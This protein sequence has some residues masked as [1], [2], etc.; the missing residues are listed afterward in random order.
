MNGNSEDMKEWTTL[1]FYVNGRRIEE[2]KADPKT[3]LA[4]YLR[5]HCKIFAVLVNFFNLKN[6][7]QSYTY[8]TYETDACVGY[9]SDFFV[10]IS[11]PSKH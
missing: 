1:L 10:E 5:D 4:T 9:S 6:S 3:T 7:S 8:I 11:V 2:K